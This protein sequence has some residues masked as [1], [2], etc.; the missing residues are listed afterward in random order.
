MTKKRAVVGA[1]VPVLEFKLSDGS[2]HDLKG[3]WT[4]IVFYPGDFTPVCSSQWCHYRDH[5]AGFSDATLVG[6][7]AGESR[8]HEDFKD[9]LGLPFCF[10]EDGDGA[11]AELFGMKSTLGFVKRGIAIVDPDGILRYCKGS[12]IGLTYPSVDVIRQRLDEVKTS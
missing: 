12:S 10:V 9:S 11:I 5:W 8:R 6:V 1:R 7:T 4:V 3:R 2:N